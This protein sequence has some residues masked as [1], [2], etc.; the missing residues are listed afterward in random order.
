MNEYIIETAEQRGIR[1]AL[2]AIELLKDGTYKSVDELVAHGL[3]KEQAERMIDIIG[4][5]KYY[6]L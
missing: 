5:K 3:S 4:V 1:I 6:I 2:S